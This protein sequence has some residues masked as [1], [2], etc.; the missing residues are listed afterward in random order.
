MLYREN[1]LNFM[2]VDPAYTDIK[3]RRRIKSLQAIQ[4]DLKNKISR[5]VE[6]RMPGYPLID[7]NDDIYWKPDWL[8]RY[9]RRKPGGFY[10]GSFG[11][12]IGRYGSKS[13]RYGGGRGGRYG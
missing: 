3:G 4:R 5:Y 10:Y 13:G 2:E 12:G 7:L 9:Q 6:K 1:E 8:N 11:S